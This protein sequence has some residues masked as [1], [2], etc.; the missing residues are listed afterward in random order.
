[1]VRRPAARA[2]AFCIFHSVPYWAAMSA[3]S[4]EFWL[5]RWLLGPDTAWGAAVRSGPVAAA[6]LAVAL[7]GLAV[8]YWA[9]AEA[10]R[11]F[12]HIVQ[13][14]RP[15]A[16]RL[17]TTGPYAWSRH[18]SYV[19]WAVWAVGTQLMLG[20]AVCAPLYAAASVAFFSAR[21]PGEEHA[22]LRWYGMEYV[23]YA[24]RVPRML[25]LVAG[26]EALNEAVRAVREAAS[27][28]REE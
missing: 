6:G 27:A 22:L 26:S 28:A 15:D 16:H 23:R 4:A 9:M 21:V 17:V 14:D 25:P 19:G 2:A 11:S 12:H 1:M 7:L 10:A 8:R 20:N 18:P 5:T 24:A 13:H 3:A